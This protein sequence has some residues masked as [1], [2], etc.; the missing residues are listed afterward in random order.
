MGLLPVGNVA[1]QVSSSY[2]ADSEMRFKVFLH[3]LTLCRTS[4]RRRN[5]YGA[6]RRLRDAET[7]ARHPA[8]GTYRVAVEGGPRQRRA[9]VN[10]GHPVGRSET[11]TSSI[12]LTSAL[13]CTNQA[14]NGA[15]RN[16]HVVGP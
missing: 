9:I 13:V 3:V 11:A 16:D 6:G 10:H 15:T 5:L 14:A 1:L 4:G 8:I 7:P 2:A 12:N